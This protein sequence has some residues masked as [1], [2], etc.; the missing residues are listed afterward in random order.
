[1]QGTPK[2]CRL[3]TTNSKKIK[4]LPNARTFQNIICK[5]QRNKKNPN[6]RNFQHILF[7]NNS[8]EHEKFTKCKDFPKYYLQTTTK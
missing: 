4:K 6:E 5:L 7:A 3:L 1:M 2:L 8:K